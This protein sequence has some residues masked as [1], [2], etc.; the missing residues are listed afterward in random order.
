MHVMIAEE[1]PALSGVSQLKE[2]REPLQH[3]EIAEVE[4]VVEDAL[5]TLRQTARL[6]SEYSIN[7]SMNAAEALGQLVS[8]LSIFG[9]LSFSDV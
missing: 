5:S 6:F 1:Q 3:Q 7:F 8:S 4:V 9:R 2:T